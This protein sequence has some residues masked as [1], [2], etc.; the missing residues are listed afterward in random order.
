M[1]VLILKYR[2]YWWQKRPR[3][4]TTS[5]SCNQHISFPTSKN[6]DVAFPENAYFTKNSGPQKLVEGGKLSFPSG[7]SAGSFAAGTFAFLQLG[8]AFQR[9]YHPLL[10][11]LSMIFPIV[12]AGSRYVDGYHH[13]H[14][15]C[16]GSIIGIFIGYY[17]FNCIIRKTKRLEASSTEIDEMDTDE[18]FLYR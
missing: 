9:F 10:L 15:I 13:L 17:I 7:H 4:S 3:P 8:L 18:T 1:L 2:G 11:M 5:Q 14:D 12:C 16:I 6:I